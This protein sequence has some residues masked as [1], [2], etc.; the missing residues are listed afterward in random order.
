MIDCLAREPEGDYNDIW[1]TIYDR[2]W[3]NLVSDIS[4]TLQKKLFVNSKLLSRETSGYLADENQNAGSA[5]IKIEFNLPKYAVLH[6]VKLQVFSEIDYGS[7]GVTFKIYD[8]DQSG[9]LLFEKTDSV[10]RGRS[11]IFIDQDFTASTLLI[12]YQTAQAD[13][14]KTEN[15]FYRTGYLNFEEDFCDF[16]LWG[17]SDYTGAVTQVNGGGINAF[18][19]VRCSVEKFVCENLNL[20][21]KA[22]LWKIGEEITIERRMGERLTR[23]T[24]FTIDRAQELS[25]FYGQQYNQEIENASKHLNIQEDPICFQC[26]PSVYA[27]TSIP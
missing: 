9:E 27:E 5:G 15:K 16:C 22:F 25:D 19:N 24:T 6:I 18:Y 21:A 11:D 20:Y 3:S 17:D 10:A 2:A 13:L 14:K 8:T 4:S 23:F 1:P 26:K 12:V 7:P